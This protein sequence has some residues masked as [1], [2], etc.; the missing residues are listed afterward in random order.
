M[1]TI[2]AINWRLQTATTG[3]IVTQI[4]THVHTFAITTREP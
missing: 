3:A 4:A 2:G 1:S